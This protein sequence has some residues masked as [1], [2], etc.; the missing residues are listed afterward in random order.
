MY[1]GCDYKWYPEG[2]GYAAW[3][4]DVDLGVSIP[5]WKAYVQCN[6]S[7]DASP[8]GRGVS[9][10]HKIA[11]LTFC[12]NSYYVSLTQTWN[13]WGKIF[14]QS[15]LEMCFSF[16]IRTLTGMLTLAGVS[17]LIFTTQFICCRFVN[18]P[19]LICYR[20]YGLPVGVLI[21]ICLLFLYFSL[22]EEYDLPE[23]K[24]C[25]LFL[26]KCLMPWIGCMNGV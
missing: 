24:E 8:Y 18:H 26:F 16:T 6:A 19:C 25:I 22:P 3:G 13:W 11:L 10:Y 4:S 15:M 5:F 20:V 14:T 2:N 21:M 12:C 1:R 23:D 7:Q 17:Y 9:V